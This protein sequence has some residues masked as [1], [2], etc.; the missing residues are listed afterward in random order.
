MVRCNEISLTIQPKRKRYSPEVYLELSSSYNR[1]PYPSAVERARLQNICCLTDIQV[2]NWFTNR[3]SRGK[4]KDAQQVVEYLSMDMLDTS[5]KL[6][7]TLNLENYGNFILLLSQDDFSC[8]TSVNPHH[9]QSHLALNPSE[10]AQ[11]NDW[12]QFM[13]LFIGSH[14][15]VSFDSQ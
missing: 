1:S 5:G 4:Q 9:D 13:E 15:G 14:G 6:S 10:S 12:S 11:H 7:H 2:N 3:R 8:S